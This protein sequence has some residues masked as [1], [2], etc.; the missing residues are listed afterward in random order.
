M[1]ILYIKNKMLDF[2]LTDELQGNFIFK[3][4]NLNFSSILKMIFRY[5]WFKLGSTVVPLIL[6][7]RTQIKLKFF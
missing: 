2:F 5:F 6:F 4:V 1:L 7:V 3:F